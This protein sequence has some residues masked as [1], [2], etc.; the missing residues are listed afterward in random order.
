[1]YLKKRTILLRGKSESVKKMALNTLKDMADLTL[2]GSI[3]GTWTDF[4]FHLNSNFGKELS[5]ALTGKIKKKITEV[6][7][8]MKS[9]FFDKINT[10][11]KKLTKNFNKFSLTSLK[12][13]SSKE[14]YLNKLKKEV[15]RIK[16]KKPSINDL[17]NIDKDKIK[18]KGK[19]LLKDLFG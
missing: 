6:E 17:K 12:D 4:D 8:K 19:K 13:M 3:E 5:N 16:D 11:K 10:Q 2:N 7:T 9:K 15:T 1:M 18:N 14:D